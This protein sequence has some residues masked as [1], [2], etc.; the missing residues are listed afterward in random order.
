MNVSNPVNVGSRPLGWTGW[1]N[2]VLGSARFQHWAARFPLTRPIARHHARDLFDLTAGFVYSQVAFALVESGLLETLRHETLS[3]P[4]ASRRAGLPREAAMRLLRAGE[5][6]RLTELL[7]DGQWTLGAR[8]A[9]LAGSPGVTAMI[10]HHRLLYQDLADPLALLRGERRG[11]LA[12][13]WDYGA[14]GEGAATYSRLMAASQPMVAA[15]ALAAFDFNRHRRLLDVGGGEGAFLATI[16]AHAPELHIGLFDLPQVTTRAATRLA[17]FAA[18]STIH[19]GDFR[20]DPLPAGYDLISLVRVLHD[21]DD[22]PAAALLARVRRALASGGRLLIVEPMAGTPGAEPAGHAYF[23]MYL[24][25]MASGRPRTPDELGA[26][27]LA[28]GF[29][30]WRILRSPLPL[31]ARVLVV[32]V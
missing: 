5:S 25:A 3:L 30:R 19:P 9:A 14:S 27:A 10:A 23:G 26:M 24:L 20:R 22:A 32:D 31:V 8:G 2:R 15:Q 12:G 21:H 17:A 1:R 28:A 16:A 6:L 29:R 11:S 18:R 4:D 7:R 13:L